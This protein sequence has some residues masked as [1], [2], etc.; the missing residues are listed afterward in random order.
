MTNTVQG[1][2]TWLKGNLVETGDYVLLGG[3]W[4]RLDER[5][6]LPVHREQQRFLG[7]RKSGEER[8]VDLVS[9]RSYKTWTDR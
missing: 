1:K 5:Q 6:S 3:F 2:F 8:T 7:V 9:T 4:Y